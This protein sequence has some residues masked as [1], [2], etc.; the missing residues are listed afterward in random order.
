MHSHR[1]F[2]HLQ[3]VCMSCVIS[4]CYSPPLPSEPLPP[5]LTAMKLRTLFLTAVL[6]LLPSLACSADVDRPDLA[7]LFTEHGVVGTFV[8]RTPEGI[9]RVNAA[10]AAERFRPASTFKILN[11][12]VALDCGVAF[13]TGKVLRWD[14]VK[15]EVPLW[16]SD[17]SMNEAFRSSAVWYFVQIAKE[18]GRER[19]GAAMREVGYGNADAT[20]SE[21]FWIDGPL[22]IS[23]EEQ[24]AWLDRLAR[25]AVPFAGRHR[26]M[27]ARMMLL[28]E[29]EAGAN[30]PAWRLLGKSGLA[31]R[32]GG[33]ASEPGDG[34]GVVADA[35]VGWLVGWLERGGVNYPYALNIGPVG[36]A[37]GEVPGPEFAPARLALVKAMLRGLKLLP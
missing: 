24:V 14:G 36:V 11:A 34:L 25:G 30:A 32:G 15:R 13:D 2:L 22:R 6:L 29:D 37:A 9:V 7:T 27:V 18:N 19:L 26:D 10:R 28:E 33:P 3:Y 4:P 31:Y 21:Q 8:V 17:L 35:P 12:L 23:A 5:Y 16:N 1:S 20:G